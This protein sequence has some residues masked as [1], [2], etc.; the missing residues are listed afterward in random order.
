MGTV[1]G[2]LSSLFQPW[3]VMATRTQYS[4]YCSSCHSY[5]L[6]AMENWVNQF[7]DYTEI[8]KSDIILILDAFSYSLSSIDD[9]LNGFIYRLNECQ[10]NLGIGGSWV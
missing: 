4:S 8:G 3:L 7:S 9:Y 2:E 10:D 6:D 5:F 1:M